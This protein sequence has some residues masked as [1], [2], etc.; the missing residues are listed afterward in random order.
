MATSM[1]KQPAWQK[2]YLNQQYQPATP[3]PP[4]PS[5]QIG[6]M[7]QPQYKPPEG[8]QEAM[9]SFQPSLYG[10]PS[11][12]PT[13]API[14][15]DT[16]PDWMRKLTEY[17]TDPNAAKTEYTRA[18]QVFNAKSAIGDTEGAA[19]A[20]KWQGQVNTAS[21]GMAAPKPNDELQPWMKAY[22]DYLTKPVTPFSYDPN[23]DPAYQA[24]LRTADTNSK[25]AAGNIAADMNKRGLLNSTM[26]AD[27]GNQAAQAEY[28][29]VSD[30]IL[31]QL[32]SESYKQY[33]DAIAQDR[34]K[35]SDTMSYVTTKYGMNQDDIVN[36]RTDTQNAITNDLATRQDRRAESQITGSYMPPGA[37]ESISAI[38][39]LKQQA[40]QEGVTPE[41]MTQFKA[42]A[43]AERNKLYQMGVDPSV[44]GFDSD[45]ATAT[46]A[47]ADYRGIPTLQAKDQAFN[48][49][50]QANQESRAAENQKIQAEG[51]TLNNELAKLK[52]A[53]YPEE[54]RLQIQKLQKDIEQIGK[55]PYQSATDIQYDQIKLDTAKEQLKQLQ[56]GKEIPDDDVAKLIESSPLFQKQYDEDG[57]LINTTV[58]VANK[59]QLAQY[60]KSL[61]LPPEKAKK[62]FIRYGLWSASGN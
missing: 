48:Q 49:G 8:M 45:F 60:I 43:D 26:T 55:I 44:V 19:A 21:G 24:A 41:Q 30:T 39:A 62:W 1:S 42:A 15:V 23:T 14:T 27:R 31:P 22:T 36:K 5:F 7:P 40:E 53:D 20:G 47:A 50:L 17:S 29:R 11:A 61:G 59:P 6:S 4:K 25:Q 37:K 13:Q 18:N 35:M 46:S 38:L 16:Q 28:S 10:Q 51:A 34:N 58:S 33:Q 32:R 12:Q 3:P 52:L 9:K 54:Q 2:A 57:K 56:T